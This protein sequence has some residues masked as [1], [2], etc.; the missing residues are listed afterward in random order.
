MEY[1]NGHSTKEEEEHEQVLKLVN[2]DG[3]NL[4]DVPA[5]GCWPLNDE[6]TYHQPLNMEAPKILPN[7]LHFIGRTPL[8]RI[9]RL[10]KAAGLKCELFSIEPAALL[11][12]LGCKVAK[13]EFFN[14]GGSVKD[15][16]GLRMVEDAEREGKLKPGM[17]VIEP[18]SGN[19]GIG[20]ALASAIKG[21][22]CIIVMPEKMSKEKV[23]TLKALGA[24]IVRTPTEAKYDSSKSHI[25]VAR[26]LNLD[27]PDSIIL[28]Q[29]HLQKRLIIGHLEVRPALDVSIRVKA[30]IQSDFKLFSP[31]KLD[32]MVVGAGTGGT[33]TGIGRKIKERCPE[34][35][36]VGADP[37]GSILAGPDEGGFYEVEGIGYDFIP[38]VIDRT[39]VDRWVK[40]KDK[41]SLETARQLIRE[42][43]LL[44][45]GSSGASMW[46]ALQ[47]A[48]DLKE[49]Q[50]CVVL[51]PDGVRNYM[52]KFL[53]DSW[54]TERGFSTGQ[55]SQAI[56][57]KNA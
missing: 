13:C 26:R 20:L 14:A 33:L 53:S 39:V 5:E 15:R 49:G 6:A 44:C 30:T 38:A 45:G 34:C 8:I 19:T 50:R 4:P 47:A 51:L 57:C 46:A 9:N 2:G 31:G 10:G 25:A 12:F 28:D 18:T 22:R 43:G 1:T 24:E 56:K 7:A 42:E 27:I 36:M 48:K 32:M 41:E 17:T 54:M 23:D 35:V 37:V 29:K 52:T 3:W 16:I 21:Y 40:T 11:G 55:S